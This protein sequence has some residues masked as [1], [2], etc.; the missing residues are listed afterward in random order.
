MAF[1]QSLVRAYL[2]ILAVFFPF[3]LHTGNGLFGVLRVSF[4]WLPLLADL[5]EP[6]T[7]V[8][9]ATGGWVYGIVGVSFGMLLPEQAQRPIV[10]S[11]KWGQRLYSMVLTFHMLPILLTYIFPSPYSFRSSGL[12]LAL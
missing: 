11:Q 6:L 12:T 3:A 2:H 7:V 5:L 10:G 8:F 4:R 9:R 1:F